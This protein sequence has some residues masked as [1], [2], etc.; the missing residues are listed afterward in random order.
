MEKKKKRVDFSKSPGGF[1][2][3]PAVVIKNKTLTHSSAKV[4]SYLLTLWS[5]CETVNPSADVIAEMT[6]ITDRSVNNARRQLSQLGLI[7]YTSG[8][9]KGNTTEYQLHGAAI[10]DFLGCE[11]CG[12]ESGESASPTSKSKVFNSFQNKYL[13]K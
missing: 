7:S 10:N 4:L 6:G 11:I 3:I 13:N 12:V 8:D 2:I 5:F 1:Y 9:G